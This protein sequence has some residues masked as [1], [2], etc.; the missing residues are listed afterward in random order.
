MIELLIGAGVVAL[1]VVAVRA[2][3]QSQRAPSDRTPVSPTTAKAQKSLRAERPEEPR[4]ADPRG[5]RVDDVLLYADSELWLAGE[6]H[7][8]EEGFALSLFATPGGRSEW[9]CQ[10]D[11]EAREIGFLSPT[12]DVPDGAVPTEL[13]AGGMRLSLRRRGQA[14]VRTRGEHL[15]LTT[16]RASYAILGGPGGRLLVVVDFEA[17][18]RLALFGERVARELVDLLP[19]G[20]RSS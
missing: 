11:A 20:D 5:L 10:L 14:D 9:A 15:P 1:G 13:P 17:G 3:R 12:S 8:D 6:I 16:E 4:G 7:F 2:L 19:G 18:D